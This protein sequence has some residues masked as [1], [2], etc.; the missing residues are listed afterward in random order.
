MFDL[1][2]HAAPDIWP[3][4]GGDLATVTA[5]AR[6]GFT[7]CVLKGH[8][9]ST[10]GRAAAAAEVTGLAVFGGI[11][12][13]RHVGGINAAAVAATLAQGGRVVWFPTSDAHAQHA[14]GLPRL[15]GQHPELSP[16]SYGI[17]PVNPETADEV[18]RICE[19]IAEADAVLATG[20]LSTAEIGWLLP[21]AARHGVRRVLLT[22]PGYTVP[23]MPAE[24]AREFASA[25]ALVEITTFQLLHQH[26]ASAAWL[27][28]YART[29]GV[30][31]VVLSS[32][33]G[34][35]DSPPPP[36]ALVLLQETLAAQ[37]IDPGS[38]RS[39]ASERAAEL[40]MPG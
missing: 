30:D 29:V 36:E 22:H 38:L 25:G 39:A 1:H 10:V 37:G 2:V 12:L 17:P 18:T 3:R 26:G 14:A 8:Y 32:D 27:A 11:A 40:V 35:P 21:V 9:E 20:H 31:R 23:A 5:Y 34:Q 24:T 6:A 13:N 15:C 19:L 16:L 33:A 28:E 7:G 4:H